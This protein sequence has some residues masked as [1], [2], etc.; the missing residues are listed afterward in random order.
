MLEVTHEGLGPEPQGLPGGLN[1][2]EELGV[3]HLGAI[4]PCPPSQDRRRR[5]TGRLHS[6]RDTVDG[7][8]G[9]GPSPGQEGREGSENVVSGG[10]WRGHRSSTKGIPQQGWRAGGTRAYVLEPWEDSHQVKKDN[11]SNCV[12]ITE[13]DS[14]VLGMRTPFGINFNW[15]GFSTR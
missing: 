1:P 4:R 14:E 8:A 2:Q 3:C 13:R 7:R 12:L 11:F 9:W 15:I 6:G 10:E 5:R